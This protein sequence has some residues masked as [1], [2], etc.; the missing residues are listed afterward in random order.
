QPSAIDRNADLACKT[1]QLVEISPE[2]KA[3]VASRSV[4]EREGS[5]VLGDPDP[6][7]NVP[8]PELR[9]PHHGVDRDWHID[10]VA[11]Q[12]LSAPCGRP[13]ASKIRGI[14]S[15]VEAEKVRG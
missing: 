10:V 9:G 14:E 7:R 8:L 3:G 5:P 6:R 2:P 12:K 1:P 4:G 11:Q 13:A 15:N